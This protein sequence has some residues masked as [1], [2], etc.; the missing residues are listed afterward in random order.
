MTKVTVYVTLRES[1]VDP[2]GIATKEGLHQLGHDNVTSVRVGKIIELEVD[3][4]VENIEQQAK[5][6]CEQLLVNQV[7]EDFRFEIEEA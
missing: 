7:I 1:V 4:S 6:M 5:E 2:V 3:G